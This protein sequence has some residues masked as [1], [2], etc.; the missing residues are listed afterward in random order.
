M[1]DK[2]TIKEQCH[3]LLEHFLVHFFYF[4]VTFDMKPLSAISIRQSDPFDSVNFNEKDFQNLA[5]VVG[6][7]G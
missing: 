4:K 1:R 5:N 2:M 6:C 7:L 3:T